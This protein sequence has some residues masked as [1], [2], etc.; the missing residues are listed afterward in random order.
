MQIFKRIFTVFVIATV[1]QPEFFADSFIKEKRILKANM[2]LYYKTLPLDVNS[3]SEVFTKGIFY[4]RLRMNSFFWD[5]KREYAGKT[6]DNKALG[7]GGSFIFKSAYLNGFGFTAGMY[8]SKNLLSPELDE[9]GYVKAGK[10]TF[11]R[12][13]AQKGNG[14][15][16]SVLA[17]LYL[18]YKKDKMSLKIG[19]QIFDSFLTKSNDTKMIPNTFEG[20]SLITGYFPNSV[21]KIAYF[22][23]QKLRDHT[24]FH[25]VITFK[26][27]LGDIWGNNDDS[28]IH[29]GLSYQNLKKAGKDTDNSLAILEWQNSSFDNLKLMFNYTFVPSL[30]SLATTE[31]CYKI[32]VFKDIKL[33]PFIRYLKQF[34]NGAGEVGGANLK[35]KTDGYK[36]P[37]SLDSHLFAAKVDIKSN[38]WMIRIGYSKVADKGDIVAPWRGFPT[39]GF[40]RAM[41]QYNWYADTKTYMIRAIYDFS[42]VGLVDGLKASVRYAIEDFDD[43]KP[44]V[45]ADA[46]VF[47]LD[48]FKKFK[49]FPGLYAKL[50]M[51]IVNGKSDTRDMNGDLKKDPSYKDYRFEINYLF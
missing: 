5:W 30:V 3:L 33:L 32:S 11:S 21:L 29:K 1:F 24:K 17:Q 18:E 27:S 41:G 36:D 50:R 7:V 40:T 10:D 47:N 4:G 43:K 49:S 51:G 46:K 8:V 26:N 38:I 15:E 12:Y 20:Y 28:A 34:D 23:K 9:I 35:G 37:L 25:D 31:I 19:R 2:T 45:Q 39:G 6:K 48:L 22:T 13:E 14:F 42:K 44:G 16:M